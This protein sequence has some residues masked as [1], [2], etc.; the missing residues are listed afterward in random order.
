MVLIVLL[1][2]FLIMLLISVFNERLSLGVWDIANPVLLAVLIS[3]AFY[4]LIFR[5]MHNQQHD[6]EELLSQL[7]CLMVRREEI[8]EEERKYI[9]REVHDELGQILTGLQLNVSILDQKCTVHC[10]TSREHVKEILML[11]DKALGVTRN[12]ALVLRPVA[13]DMGIVS[14]LKWLAGR[15]G[16][17]TGI[18]CEVHIE[19]TEIQFEENLAIALF[20]ILQESL[21]NVARHA[22]ADTVEIMLGT[23]GDDYVL[24]VRDD[25][26]GFDSSIKKKNSFG[27]VGI[28][29]RVIMLAGT[30]F[31]NSRPGAGT[32]I[33]V[34]L[35]INN[36]SRKS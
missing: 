21:T 27:L 11:T 12:V 4:I 7:R 30:V 15:F 5:P 34:R 29:E 17:N 35:P 16:S 14:A 33:V 13:L 28:R 31:I 2:E 8:R 22:G 25:G 1:A 9:A 36:N 26:Q 3:P 18:Q 19:E 10:S 24:K 20:R 23:E 32:E 6:L